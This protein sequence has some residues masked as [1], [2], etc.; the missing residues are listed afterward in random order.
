MVARAWGAPVG[1]VLACVG[2]PRC[3]GTLCLRRPY[4]VGILSG[5][6]SGAAE[7]GVCPKIITSLE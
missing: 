3:G 2:F 1:L 4:D 6:Q 5:T 7:R